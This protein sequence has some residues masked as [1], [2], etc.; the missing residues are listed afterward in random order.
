M[1]ADYGYYVKGSVFSTLGSYCYAIFM[2]LPYL[3]QSPEESL[4]VL[5]E[6]IVSGYQAK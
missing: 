2:G 6:C 1:I 3:K 5:D 4:R